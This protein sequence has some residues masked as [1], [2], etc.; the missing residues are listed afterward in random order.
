MLHKERIVVLNK[1]D[2]VS[3][4][5]L[6]KWGKYFRRKGEVVAYVSALTGHRV[7]ELKELVAGSNYSPAL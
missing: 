2:L 4:A 5:T 7:D 6:T 1:A 3:G